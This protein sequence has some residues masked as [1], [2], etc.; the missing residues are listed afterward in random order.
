MESKPAVVVENVGRMY[1]MY[2][3]PQ[4]RL[5]QAF[6][7]GRKRLYREF[8]ALRNVSI[9]VPPGE[10][11]GI[12]GRNGSGK[13]TLLQIIAGTLR[14]SQ[15]SV[16]V[17]GR[18]AALLELGSGFHPQFSGRENVYVNGAI[19]GLSRSEIDRKLPEI[20]AF[21]EIGEFID[22]PL[23]TY[24]SGMV[25]R[26]A[27]AVQVV[28][29][30]DVL[31]IDE[32]LSVGDVFFQQKCFKKIREILARGTTLLLVSHDLSAVQNLCDRVLLLDGGQTIFQ[33]DAPQAIARYY[34]MVGAVLPAMA[35]EEIP[36]PATGSTDAAPFAAVK[37]R[38]I[39]DPSSPNRHGPRGL[40]IAAA[41]VAGDDGRDLH[42]VEMG[43]R[44]A[45]ELLVRAN[46]ELFNRFGTLVFGTGAL[47]QGQTLPS[48]Q[49]GDELLIRFEIE[50]SIEPGEYTFALAAATV[51]ISPNPNVG[52]F[53]DRFEGMGPLAV[54][55]NPEILH[56]FYGVARLPTATC[57]QICKRDSR[58]AGSATTLEKKEE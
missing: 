32:A 31:I 58:Q 25:V 28:V 33:G 56:P 18:S 6:L 42:A 22:Q 49:E 5:K 36:A 43:G 21:A 48:M 11:F 40:E 34:E 41:R 29:E 16:R 52:I 37:E 50:L 14:P 57:W 1:H 8:W 44:V 10:A 3:R 51:A 24:S 54:H 27:F 46:R 4:D 47:Q 19:L 55:A 53:E 26:L 20:E 39:L 12:I 2:E 30:P 17:T 9:A 23:T 45:F 15:G 7:W 38:N 13:S 35:G